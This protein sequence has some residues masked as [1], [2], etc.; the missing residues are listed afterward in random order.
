MKKKHPK[1]GRGVSEPKIIKSIIQNVGYLEM[2][3]GGGFSYIQMTEIW[4]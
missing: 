2:I 1:G 3:G 4:P